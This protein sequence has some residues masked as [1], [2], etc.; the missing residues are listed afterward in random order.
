MD[1]KLTEIVKLA[2]D[3]QAGRSGNHATKSQ[4]Y[5]AIQKLAEE[6]RQP[7]E[8]AQKAFSRVVTSDMDGRVM[9]KCYMSAAGDDYRPAAEPAPVLKKD[10]AYSKLKKIAGELKA[11]N[12]SLTDGAAFLK[13]FNENRELAALSKRESA[14]AT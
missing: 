13:A 5:L 11:E 9:F 14:F 10:S 8:T 6:Q 7:R 1:Q 3:V 12:P 4:W 2:H